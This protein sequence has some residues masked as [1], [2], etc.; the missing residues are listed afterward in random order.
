MTYANKMNDLAWNNEKNMIEE[1]TNKTGKK[2]YLM[3]LVMVQEY[4]K[5]RDKNGIDSTEAWIIFMRAQEI[6]DKIEDVLRDILTM[7]S[8]TIF[9]E[10]ERIVPNPETCECPDF[11]LRI[12]TIADKLCLLREGL[13]KYGEPNEKEALDAKLEDMVHRAFNSLSS[14][15]K[16]I[17]I[18]SVD[19]EGYYEGMPW[20][21]WEVI[22]SLPDYADYD[23]LLVKVE[24]YAN[25]GLWYCGKKLTQED[26]QG[27]ENGGFSDVAGLDEVKD[28]LQSDFIDVMKEPVRA[29]K[30]GIDLPNGMLLYGPPGCGKTVFATKFA[31]EAGCNFQIVNCSDIASSFLHGTQRKIAETFKEAE[32]KIPS[33]IFFDE[34][35]AMIP[36]RGEHGNE[37]YQTET[38]EFLTQLN[39]S[40][41]RGIFVIGATNRPQDI[42]PAALRSGR[43]EMKVYF[44]AP[45]DETRA[46]LF[47][48]YLKDR[49]IRGRIDID[50]LVENTVD[51]VSADIEKIVELAA[52]T[53]FRKKLD[54]VTMEMIENVIKTFKPTVSKA[55]LRE[56][57]AI[58]DKFEG[59]K[60]E[61]PRIGFY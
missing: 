21:E 50:K 13:A 24:E 53:A 22:N 23:A 43:L 11:P 38:N 6:K 34:I 60:Q 27:V 12:F 28:L 9:P 26:M 61:R 10:I 54:Y 5:N 30:L 2:Q 47:I 33:I 7:P 57:E 37:Y 29:Q 31:E 41:R 59:R 51:Y 56:H 52:R 48:H 32:K 14:V 49:N 46:S 42:D 35:E 1:M 8:V 36:K 45:D 44:P 20:Y 15:E 55:D 16:D 19:Y 17:L 4:Q 39:H 18:C 3:D 40:G 58:R 25:E